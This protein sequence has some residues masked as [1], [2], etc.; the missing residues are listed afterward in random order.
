[1]PTLADK[2]G[3]GSLFQQMCRKGHRLQAGPDLE[4]HGDTA[5]WEVFIHFSFDDFV[6]KNNSTCSCV[7]IKGE[8]SVL[9]I[10]DPIQGGTVISWESLCSIHTLLLILKTISQFAFFVPHK[11]LWTAFLV[12]KTVKHLTEQIRHM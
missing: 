2:K 7:L 9:H 4:G 11:R 8:V 12:I 1:M 5:A 10:Q 3:N 6:I